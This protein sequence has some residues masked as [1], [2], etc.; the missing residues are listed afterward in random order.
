MERYCEELLWRSNVK[1]CCG[2]ILWSI[3]VEN[4][5]E[6]ICDIPSER[7]SCHCDTGIHSML[8]Y[9]HSGRFELKPFNSFFPILQ[10]SQKGE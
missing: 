4:Y 7:S 3:V 1:Y 8:S 2:E 5:C 6:E 10:L 9:G